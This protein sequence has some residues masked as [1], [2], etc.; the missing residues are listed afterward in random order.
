MKKK[1]LSL[2]VQYKEA[3]D[4]LRESSHAVYLAIVL[5]LLSAISGFIFRAH[6]SLIDDLLKDIIEKTA[7]LNAPE[8]IFFILQNNLQSAFLSVVLGIFLGIFPIFS[9]VSNGVVAG[10]VLGK[11]YEVAG[12]ASWWRLLPHGIFELPAI[13]IAFGLGIKLGSSI[14]AKNQKEEFKRRFYQAMNVFLMIIIPLLI[15]AAIIEGLL[16]IFL[17]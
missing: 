8:M 16:I 15:I 9:A 1:D 7:N 11:T 17:S 14:F 3:K 13:F 6:L 10:Y 12:I 2:K 4:Y 5:F